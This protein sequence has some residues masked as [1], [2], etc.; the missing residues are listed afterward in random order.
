[1]NTPAPKLEVVVETLDDALNAEQGGAS[2]VELVSSFAVGGLTPAL[3][4]VQAVGAAVGIEVHV[5]LRPHAR[6][7]VY[8]PDEQVSMLRTAEC[9]ART[10]VTGIVVGGLL[11]DG[12]VDLQLLQYI[13]NVIGD[14]I[15]ITLH[16]AIDSSSSPAEDIAAASGIVNRVLTTGTARTAWQGR[17]RLFHWVQAFGDK[18]MIICGGGVSHDNIVALRDAVRAPVYHTGSAA[19]LKGQVDTGR[20]H[21]LVELLRR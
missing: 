1:M 9:F 4:T 17:D 14:T 21:Q 19:R 6:D 5:M 3:E 20:V 18:V 8:T 13:R 7:F 16:R 12:R 11:P 15:Q 10:G 2:C